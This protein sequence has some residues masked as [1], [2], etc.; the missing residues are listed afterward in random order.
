MSKI[1][2]DIPVAQRYRLQ[3]AF[4]RPAGG[5]ETL[6]DFISE[7]AGKF[8]VKSIDREFA[9]IKVLQELGVDQYPTDAL[10]SEHQHAYARRIR[11]RRPTRFRG[12]RE[13][14][15]TI[16]L[17]SF[18]RHSLAEHT[19]IGVDMIDRRVA[20]LWRRAREEAR[21]DGSSTSERTFVERVR[22]VVSGQITTDAAAARLT[23][24]K[25][26][27][28]QLDEGTLK[29]LAPCCS[30]TRDPREAQ[31][32]DPAAGAKAA[33]VRSSKRRAGELAH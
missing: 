5:S 11:Q 12:Q 24:V 33:I 16:E 23:E 3:D 25:E 7:L 29:P 18:Y 17:V 9:R 30:A 14:R 22:L 19:D 13:P 10:T 15:R 28:R 4:F 27:L 31:R 1:E 6:I 32:P 20:Q 8:S 26:L 2:R 21:G